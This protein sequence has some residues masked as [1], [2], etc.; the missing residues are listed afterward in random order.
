M[1]VSLGAGQETLSRAWRSGGWLGREGH[2][3]RRK[4]TTTSRRERA[5]KGPKTCHRQPSKLM[6]DG[7]VEK[8]TR[9]RRW[10]R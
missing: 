10:R 4:D 3:R 6:S 5:T 1:C 8:Q 7:D 2:R 9:E